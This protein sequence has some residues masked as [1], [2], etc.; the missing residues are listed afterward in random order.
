[1]RIF[2]RLQNLKKKLFQNKLKIKKRKRK[3]QLSK[4]HKF[5]KK[6]LKM[7]GHE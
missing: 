4:I 5:N 2:K 1:M 3:L 6:I 7:N